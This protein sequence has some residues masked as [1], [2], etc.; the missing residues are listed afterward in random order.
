MNDED[1]LG[2]TDELRKPEGFQSLFIPDWEPLEETVL[3]AGS[4]IMKAWAMGILW[5]M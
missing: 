2:N 3:R 4:A 5:E 1:S